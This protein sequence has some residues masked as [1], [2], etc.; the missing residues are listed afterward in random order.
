[1]PTA[2]A[3]STTRPCSAASNASRAPRNERPETVGGVGFNRR[4]RVIGSPIQF[5]RPARPGRLVGHGR[6]V[7][8]GRQVCFMAGELLCPDGE[9]VAVA[10]A[11]AHIQS[12][13]PQSRQS[14]N[15]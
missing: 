12:L 4:R 7:R 11:T 5:L 8:R 13:D 14:V 10:T 9:P 2:T 6:V 3:G 1:M 15:E